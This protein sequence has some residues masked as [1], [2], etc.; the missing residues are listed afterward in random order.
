VSAVE[1]EVD[2]KQLKL[3]NLDKVFYPETG[4]TKGQV[5]DYYTRV[6]PALLPHLQGRPLTMKR[7]PNGVNGK[8]FYEKECPKHRPDWVRTKSIEA[9]GSTKD[10]THVNFCIVDDL[11]TLVWV[12]NLADL[13]MHTS[14]SRADDMDH[15]TAVAFDLDPGPG[16]TIVECSQIALWL[17]ELFADLKLEGYP[18]TS[19]SKGL[20]VYVPLNRGEATY[21]DTKP[22]ALAV[23]QLLEQ[24]HPELIVSKMK[25][26]LRKNKVLVDW[27]QNDRHKTTVCVYSL[28]GMPLPSVSTPVTWDEVEKAV[29]KKDPKLLF[30]EAPEVLKRVEK[31]GDLFEP[32]LTKKQKLPTGIRH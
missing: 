11:A 16:T 30:F 3:S 27:S 24:Q 12:A 18:K 23:A 28:R 20:Q 5:I 6:A 1:V 25:K 32:V 29:K 4:F 9:R 22:F 21:A 31:Q 10:R 15:P 14:L 7:Y 8:F 26:E 17:R 13:E 2:G 19:G